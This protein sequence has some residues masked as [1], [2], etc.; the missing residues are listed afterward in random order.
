M[1]IDA[2]P[3]TLGDAVAAVIRVDDGRYLLQKRDEKQGIWYPGHWGC[4]GGGVDDGELPEQALQRELLE[5]LNLK[6]GRPRACFSL[7]FDLSD[8]GKRQYY[9][10]YFDIRIDSDALGALVLGEGA[11][12]RAFQPAIMLDQVRLTP[13]DAF[14]LFLHYHRESL[15]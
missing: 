14:A 11:G 10:R 4:F 2:N 15:S 7:N 3:L 5:E 6:V 13:Y 1:L 12:L 8:I 9:R